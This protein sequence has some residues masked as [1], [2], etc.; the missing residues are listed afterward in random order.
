MQLALDDC[1]RIVALEAVETIS[2]DFA[3]IEGGEPRP[4]QAMLLYNIREKRRIFVIRQSPLGEAENTSRVC[5]LFRSVDA[6]GDLGGILIA[7]HSGGGLLNTKSAALKKVLA[8]RR[9][10]FEVFV[11][12]ESDPVM[13][14]IESCL[15]GLTPVTGLGSEIRHDILNHFIPIKAFLEILA[16]DKEGVKQNL[17][18]EPRELDNELARARRESVSRIEK[19]SGAAP[20]DL[21][22]RI[23]TLLLSPGS[24]DFDKLQKALREARSATGK[25]VD[26]K[27]AALL[28]ERSRFNAWFSE[29]NKA[30]LQIPGE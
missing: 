24:I 28:S 9:H 19:Y 10:R 14:K 23:K 1:R 3:V 2:D 12:A 16:E 7:A 11:H 20:K 8:G 18:L 30:L 25:Q 17:V 6:A 13:R 5:R 26:A 21:L 29:L 15:A 27:L 4:V 22:D